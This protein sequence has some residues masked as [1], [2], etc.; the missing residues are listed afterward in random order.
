MH[1]G[2]RLRTLLLTISLAVSALHGG[3]VQA[4][5]L[6]R[7][8][9]FMPGEVLVGFWDNAGV[10]PEQAVQ[11]IGRIKP[12]AYNTGVARVELNNGVSIA[13]AIA[14]LQGRPGVR[15]A[16][17]NYVRHTTATPNDPNYAGK[18]WGPQ[19]VKMPQ[20]WDI[21]QPKA[22]KV[23]AIIDTGV[24]LDHSDLVGVLLKDGTGAIVGYNAQVPASSPEDDHG[25][26]THC[27]GI[28]AG[29]IDNSIGIAGI[30]GWN[31]N[32]AGSGSY[33]KIMP[34]K[35]LDAT[36]YGSD[37]EV[38]AGIRWAVDHGASVISMSLGGTDFSTTLQDACA[39]MRGGGK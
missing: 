21:W 14:A 31:P 18:Q 27:A 32:V 26:G 5:D 9:R 12:R 23:V 38:A 37:E 36:G 17:P 3:T 6:A 20:V 15:Y 13:R 39:G 24:D 28:A 10:T 25:H 7:P 33:V 34:V 2:S 16:E 19:R 30:A 11:G 8:Q 35:V 4:E 1:F 29:Q 22:E